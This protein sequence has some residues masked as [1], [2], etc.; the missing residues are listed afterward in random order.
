MCT[1]NNF[2]IIEVHNLNVEYEL[3]H[4][5]PFKIEK[6]KDKSGDATEDGSKV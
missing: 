4:K 6:N 2:H 1:C 5:K 3:V